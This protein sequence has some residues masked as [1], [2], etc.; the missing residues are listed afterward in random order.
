MCKQ[1]IFTSKTVYNFIVAIATKYQVHSVQLHS[2]VSMTTN[3]LLYNKN[4]Y[5]H[6]T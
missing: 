5:K 6:I 3:W 1:C 2:S 4:K